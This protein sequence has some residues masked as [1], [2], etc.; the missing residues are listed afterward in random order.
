MADVAKLF[1]LTVIAEQLEEEAKREAFRNTLKKG[2]ASLRDGLKKMKE[3]RE[4]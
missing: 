4:R 1:L 3:I 2:T